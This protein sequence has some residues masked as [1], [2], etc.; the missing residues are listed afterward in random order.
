MCKG[1]KNPRLSQAGEVVWSINY[2]ICI[3]FGRKGTKN[4]RYS[5]TGDCYFA[6]QLIFSIIDTAKVIVK[7]RN[8]QMIS[9][10]SFIFVRKNCFRVYTQIYHVATCRIVATH[11]KSLYLQVFH[12]LAVATKTATICYKRVATALFRLLLELLYQCISTLPGYLCQSRCRR[13]VIIYDVPARQH[14]L[15]GTDGGTLSQHPLLFV[16]QKP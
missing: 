11:A 7:S 10:K 3:L 5:R 6:N 13:I 16:I 1:T 8:R 14:P 9:G 2:R 4:P 12:S 15:H